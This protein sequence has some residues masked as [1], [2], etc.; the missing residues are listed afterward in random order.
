MWLF[1]LLSFPGCSRIP[2]WVPFNANTDQDIFRPPTP[3][4]GFSAIKTLPPVSKTA[5]QVQPSQTA[6]TPTPACENDLQFIEDLNIP[7]NSVVQAGER[8]VKQWE[9][10]NSGTCN[11]DSTYR[12]HFVSGSDFGISPQ[13]SLYPA[14]SGT[15]AVVQIEFLVPETSGQY[16]SAWQAFSPGGEPFGDQIYLQINVP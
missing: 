8:L 13:L 15:E 9:V 3:V 1:L 12:L 10:A 5:Q 14:R 7:D 4:G 2:A 16:R 11:W 6:F